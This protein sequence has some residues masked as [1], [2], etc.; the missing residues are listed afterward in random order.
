MLLS[1]LKKMW[2][3]CVVVFGGP[4]T[5]RSF[6]NYPFVDCVITGEGEEGFYDLLKDIISQNL[7]QPFYNRKRL[8]SLDIPSPYTTGVFDTLIKNNPDIIWSMVFETNRGCP[9]S[10]T[11][12]DWG[13]TTQSK[14]KKFDI[15]KVQDEL[16]WIIGKPIGY[17]FNADANYGIFKERDLEIAKLIKDVADR[18]GTVDS[19]VFAY[20]KN[21]NQT[22]FEI[23][24][25]LGKYA[26]GLT[27]AVQSMHDNT[28]TAIKRK[29]MDINNI[30][31]MMTLAD[32]YNVKVYTDVILGLPEETVDSFK[33]GLCD[34]IDS[35]IH[36]NIYIW[37]AQ[38]LP[39][40]EM[41][42]P[43]SIDRFGIRSIKANDY[44][45]YYNNKD[46][47]NIEET[48]DLIVET[49]TM[50]TND[51]VESYLYA[52]MILHF[53][54]KGYSQ[55][56]SKYT[57]TQNVSYRQFYD[58]LF[59]KIQTLDFLTDHLAQLKGIIYK[60]FTTGNLVFPPHSEFD[61]KFK[62]GVSS[63][64]H[65]IHQASR[66]YLENLTDK[67]H[68]LAITT[69]ESFCLIPNS[70]KKEQEI[71]KNNRLI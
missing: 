63:G 58:T 18:S 40:S 65:S 37:F 14:I 35:G 23:E 42:S 9:Y 33:Q 38:L 22:V 32:Q 70:V 25:T 20:A 24:K 57:R 11:F 2:P 34:I 54:N 13:S 49:N 7:V 44:M 12:C 36:D 67:L 39:N 47:Y 62:K 60:Y 4:Q 21:S 50:S 17:L 66:E 30:S 27:I 46:F 10:C 5:T 51:L 29:N 52:W 55:I 53:H 3:N 26:K 19:V 61:N 28:L 45:G 48:V 43:E 71:F 59:D 8:D 1:V 15:K 56:I 16:E 31:N 41:A 69:G 68:C 6:L 64:G